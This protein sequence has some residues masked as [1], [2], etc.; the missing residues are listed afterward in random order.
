MEDNSKL[1]YQGKLPS[2]IR[3]E[4]PTG[5]IDCSIKVLVLEIVKF[6]R[7]ELDMDGTVLT[8]ETLNTIIEDTIETIISSVVES[9]Q[10]DQQS[11]P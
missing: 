1:S 6:I 7:I 4:I 5:T 10:K 3:F 9:Q 2:V 11:T 8:N